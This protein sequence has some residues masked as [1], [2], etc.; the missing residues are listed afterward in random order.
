MLS[1]GSEVADGQEKRHFA[2]EQWHCGRGGFVHNSEVEKALSDG[3]GECLQ[4]TEIPESP[5]T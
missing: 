1:L 3:N 5:V 4:W 2:L